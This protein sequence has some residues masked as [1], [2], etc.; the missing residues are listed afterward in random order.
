MNKKQIME[1]ATELSV[2]ASEVRTTLS[3]RFF[4][5]ET[6]EQIKKSE[7]RFYRKIHR[8]EKLKAQLAMAMLSYRPENEPKNES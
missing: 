5:D 6:E 7:S 4:A 1:L 2:Q 3:T 8:I